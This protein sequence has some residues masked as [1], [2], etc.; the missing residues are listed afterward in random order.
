M[1]EV[2]S[3]VNNWTR[4][5]EEGE[6]VRLDS[7]ICDSSDWVDSPP[8]PEL[9]NMGAGACWEGKVVRIVL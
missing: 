7:H 5:F 1:G 9:L 3:I 4:W 2:G 6:V 8:T